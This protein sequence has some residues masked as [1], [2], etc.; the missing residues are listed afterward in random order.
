MRLGMGWMIVD[1]P[2]YTYG[3][4][5]RFIYHQKAVKPTRLMSGLVRLVLIEATEAGFVTSP[6]YNHEA[7]EISRFEIPAGSYKPDEAIRV[8]GELTL[9]TYAPSV[10]IASDNR[11]AYML[12]VKLEV[13]DQ[14]TRELL[15]HL[16]IEPAVENGVVRTMKR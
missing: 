13:A 1:K 11:M 5:I 6:T 15:Y 7:I 8:R 2:E 16:P 4:T 12:E 10:L 9:P 14:P 3:D